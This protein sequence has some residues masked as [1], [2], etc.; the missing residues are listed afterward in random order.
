MDEVEY[1]RRMDRIYVVYGEAVINASHDK[2]LAI[3]A[4]TD[5]YNKTRGKK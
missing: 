1:R 5:E 3:R 4:L 2:D